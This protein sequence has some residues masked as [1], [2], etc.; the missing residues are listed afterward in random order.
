MKRV[1]VFAIA[2]LLAAS[3]AAGESG[4]KAKIYIHGGFV[5]GKAYLDMPNLRKLAYVTGLLDGMFLAPVVGGTVTRQAWFGLCVDT[6]GRPGI[7]DI[8]VRRLRENDRTWD[9]RN[10]AKVYRAIRA[11]CKKGEK[12]ASAK[13]ERRQQ[14]G[15]MTGKTYL[16]MNGLQK[17]SYVGGLVEGVFL[18]PAF[19]ANAVA[20][21]PFVTCVDRLRWSGVLKAVNKRLL[22]EPKL[23]GSY[24]PEPRFRAILAACAKAPGEQK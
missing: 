19:G 8:L 23:W 14:G 13:P 15:Y 18:T 4:P 11:G 6:L 21:K 12:P 1:L 9:N 2:A 10:P 24:D 22:A 3:T 7:R 17:L 5:S 16:D 20:L